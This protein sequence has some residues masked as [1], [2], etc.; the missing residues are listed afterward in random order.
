MSAAGLHR[1]RTISSVRGSRVLLR[2]TAILLSAAA[3]M[4]AVVVLRAETRRY[5][6]LTADCD[7]QAQHL[8]QELHEKEFE[9]AR[10][11]DPARIREEVV[12]K[13]LAEELGT[14][15]E[16]RAAAP[17]RSGGSVAPSRPDVSPQRR[18]NSGARGNS[19]VRRP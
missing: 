6:Y 15:P 4:L 5:E 19:P 2:V 3:I 7:W 10:L 13:K 17:T 18:S 9:L 11:R 14:P 8:R 12:G 16:A 1:R